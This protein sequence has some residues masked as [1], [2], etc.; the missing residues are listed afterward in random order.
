MVKYKNILSEI[1]KDKKQWSNLK[2]ELSKHNI[3]NRSLGQKDTT[4]GIVFEVFTKYYFLT[5]PQE[6]E[7]L[8]FH[9][10]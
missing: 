7:Y 10:N 1:I 6:Q 8:N 9:R 3:D 2:V 5:A 4:A